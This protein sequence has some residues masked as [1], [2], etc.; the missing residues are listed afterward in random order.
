MQRAATFEP[1]NLYFSREVQVA[2]SGGVGAFNAEPERSGR[3]D[4]EQEFSRIAS[5]AASYTD[6]FF[7]ILFS[8]ARSS[9][10]ASGY[11]CDGRATP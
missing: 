4:D 6:C 11:L 8:R 9:R 7:A 3:S 1:A 10:P 2:A 5:H